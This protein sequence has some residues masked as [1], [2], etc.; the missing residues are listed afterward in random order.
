M[1]RKWIV[2]IIS[3]LLI[4]L[5]VYASVSKLLAYDDF[6]GAL[7]NQPIPSW[8]AAILSWLLPIAEL[9]TAGL[10]MSSRLRLLGLYASC[11]LMLIFTGYVGFI[12]AGGFGRIP[13]SC[14]GILK[15]MGWHVHFIFNIF[16]LLLTVVGIILFN[17]KQKIER[18][19]FSPVTS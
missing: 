18:K 10:L 15:N 6:R 4:S 12:L 3:A 19:I 16:F 17:Q 13:C 14:G 5:F 2:E 7:L 9:V 11:F 1:R 8:G